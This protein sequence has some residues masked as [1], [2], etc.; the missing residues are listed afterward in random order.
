V[1]P[2]HHHEHRNLE[3]IKNLIAH[4]SLSPRVKDQATRIF[5]RLAQAEAVVHGTTPDRIHFHEVGADDAIVDIVGACVALELLGIDA[6]YCSEPVTGSGTVRCAHGLMPVPAPATLQM[7]KGLT[8]HSGPESAELLT[9]TG[10][11]ILTTLAA[12]FGPMPALRITANGYGAGTRDYEGLSNVL[13]LIVGESAELTQTPQDIVVLE[14]T[15]DDASGEIIGHTIGVLLECGALDAVALPVVMKKSRPGVILQVLAP[16][17]KVKPLEQVL[18][19]E[20]T[21][22]GLRRYRCSRTIL[23]RRQATV[24][25]CYGP[26]QLK[27]AGSNGLELTV[28]P[29][30]EDCR[31]AAATHGVSLRKVYQEALEAYRKTVP[32]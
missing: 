26:V 20:T 3:I 7:L 31:K 24:T 17:D 23:E 13:R 11:A 1:P 27:I 15:L 32:Q 6:V 28:S 10:A 25:T 19:A 18:F 4:A 29:E 22:F 12:G 9:P 21:T 8:V 16:I 14:A 2:P 30:Y 5:E